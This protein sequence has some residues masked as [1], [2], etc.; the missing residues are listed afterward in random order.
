M[1]KAFPAKIGISCTWKLQKFCL[2]KK[3]KNTNIFWSRPTLL[4]R[5]TVL[6]GQGAIKP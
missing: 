3:I 5:I 6:R 2:N 1:S 4:P